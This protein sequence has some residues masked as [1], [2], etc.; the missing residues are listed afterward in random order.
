MSMSYVRCL[1]GLGSGQEYSA[2]QPMNLDPIDGRPVE[3]VLDIE[4]LAREQPG[5]AWYRP[6]RRDLWRFGGLMALDINDPVDAAHIVTLGEG[7]TPLLELEH[8]LAFSAG[9]RLQL[10]EEGRAVPGYGANPTQSFK[11]RGM[12]MV[13]A[14]ARRLGLS[15]LAVPTQGNAG[16]SLVRYALAG[17]LS[18]HVAMPEDTPLPILGS[19]AAAALK[20]PQQVRL[21]LVGPTIREAGAFLKAEV[22]PQGYF[23]V[24]TFQEPGWRIEGKKSLGLELAEPLPGETRW[25]L[26][27]AVIYPTGGG[28]GVLGMWKAWNELEQ[29][30][31]IDSRRPRMLCVQSE[32]TPPLVQA[33][34]SGAADS[35][36]VTAGHTLSTG[37]NVPGGVGHFKVLEI[38]RASGGAALA[39]SEADTAAEVQRIW[40]GQR[41]WISPEGAACSAAVAQLLDR[42]LLKRGE[43]VVAVNTGSAE[44]YLPEMRHLLD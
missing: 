27:D 37:L 4:R 38:I 21:S 2:D 20:H 44:K 19:V 3:M 25:Q 33:F 17:G 23:L 39:V 24:A 42:G 32:A 34:E 15:K 13:T 30:G 10:K 43:R 11:D 40:R 28:T 6:E 31:L 16:D 29:L 22:V 7:C 9:L 36:P 12:A 14:Q 5:L 41:L 18:V 35:T 8:P 26:P 1:R